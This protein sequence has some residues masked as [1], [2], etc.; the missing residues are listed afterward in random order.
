VQ[1]GQGKICEGRR[2]LTIKAFRRVR[3]ECVY[4]I[5]VVGEG[6]GG[7]SGLLAK[8]GD[9]VP[10]AECRDRELDEGHL[11]LQTLFVR[12]SRTSFRGGGSQRLSGLKVSYPPS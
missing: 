5:L 10:N 11:H 12:R 2:S 3:C 6:T 1:E 7:C 4:A 9:L 8:M